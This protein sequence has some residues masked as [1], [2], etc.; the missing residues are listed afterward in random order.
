M[1]CSTLVPSYYAYLILYSFH[2]S[3]S[4][5]HFFLIYFIFLNATSKSESKIYRQNLTV[6]SVADNPQA[7]VATLL[8]LHCRL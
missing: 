4:F 3:F 7:Y 5:L 6:L 8:C 1:L 2:F